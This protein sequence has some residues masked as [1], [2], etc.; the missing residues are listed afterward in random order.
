[1]PKYRV[2]I[3]T[4]D[5]YLAVLRPLAH[6][7]NKY[8]L[9]NPEVII[10]GFKEPDFDL[11]PNF[12]FISLGDMKDYPLDKW[13]DQLI[14]LVE[15]VED[16]TFILSMDDMLPV[17]PVDAE[18]VQILFDYMVQFQYV[19]RMDLTSDRQFAWGSEDYG[20]VS[21]LHL[22]KSHPDSQYTVSMMPCAW[23]RRHFFNIMESGKNPWQV[24]LQLSPKMGK[25]MKDYGTLVLGTKDLPVK[26]TLAMRGGDAGKLACKIPF[27]LGEEDREE[28]KELGLLEP[29]L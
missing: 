21:R 23:N 17:G 26:V 18:A 19:A 11:P 7:Y 27:E 28:M 8:W 5:H 12:T 29:W 3:P 4:C 6:L 1:M 25:V 14:K 2:L 15:S 16:E 10:G 22:V 20:V 13:S 9:P 24:E